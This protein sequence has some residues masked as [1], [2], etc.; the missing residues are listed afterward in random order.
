MDDDPRNAD[1]QKAQLQTMARSAA[2]RYGLDESELAL[3]FHG[4]NATFRTRLPGGPTMLLRLHGDHYNTA[5]QIRSELDVL[6]Y[7]ADAGLPVQRPLRPDGITPPI[8][9]ESP[10]GSDVFPGRWASVLTWIHGDSVR[11]HC[12]RTGEDLGYYYQLCGALMA[13]LHEALEAFQPPSGFDRRTWNRRA[14]LETTAFAGTMDELWRLIPAEHRT[15]LR[16]QIDWAG[17]Q[18][19]AAVASEPMRLI[20]GDLHLSN[21]IVTADGSIGAIDFDDAG[22]GPR[23]YDVAASVKTPDDASDAS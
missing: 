1:W 11:D 16:E 20:H 12:K 23:L 2:S 8:F 17:T 3:I 10:A 7:L 14:L 13:R 9:V 5:E 21:I 4:E 15:T 22:F 6:A 18:V 19:D